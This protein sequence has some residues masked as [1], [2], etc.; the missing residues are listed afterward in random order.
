MQ[1]G[2]YSATGIASSTG[3]VGAERPRKRRNLFVILLEALYESR[4]RKTERVL[5]GYQSLIDRIER[6][7]AASRTRD[8]AD[9]DK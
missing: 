3:K 2:S 6:R 1:D 4:R 5:L 9:S 7:R 8:R